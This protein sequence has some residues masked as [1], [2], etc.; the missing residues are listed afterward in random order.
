MEDITDAGY[1]HTKIVSKNFE[2]KKNSEYHDL[3]VQRDTILLADVLN[4]FQK[5]C[6]EMGL[7]LLIFLQHQDYNS[8]QH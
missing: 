5:M 7:I 8:K 2:I 4:N 3:Y 6:L 1:T